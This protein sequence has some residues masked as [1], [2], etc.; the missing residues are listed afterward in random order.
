MSS[1]MKRLERSGFIIDKSNHFQVLATKEN[2]RPI[3]IVRNGR[4]DEAVTLAVGDSCFSTVKA[5]LKFSEGRL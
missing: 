5:A 2:C 1:T 3:K 4:S